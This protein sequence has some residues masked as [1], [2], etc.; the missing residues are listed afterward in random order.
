MAGI[1][2]GR[3][4]IAL[5]DELFGDGEAD[6]TTRTLS[7]RMEHQIDGNAIYVRRFGGTNLCYAPW[8]D[9][10]E[11]AA[12]TSYGWSIHFMTWHRAT[13]G[14]P[15]TTLEVYADV[16]LPGSATDGK[17]AARLDAFGF[18]DGDMGVIAS[19]GVVEFDE[20]DNSI[21][22]IAVDWSDAGISG[23][24]KILLVLWMKSATNETSG[25]SGTVLYEDPGLI[26]GSTN[27]E[28]EIDGTTY[29]KV[30]DGSGYG[31]VYDP[32][33]QRSDGAFM[34]APAFAPTSSV[35][36]DVYQMSVI[37]TKAIRVRDTID[38][39]RIGDLWTPKEPRE[40]QAQ[41][42]V[43]GQHTRSHGAN[44]DE[45]YL[46]PRALAFGPTGRAKPDATW[47]GNRYPRWMTVA[48]DTGGTLDMYGCQIDGTASRLE[49]SGWLH[50]AYLEPQTFRSLER[51]I[52]WLV[53]LTLT[54]KVEQLKPG[55]DWSG[56]TNYGSESVDLDRVPMY[57]LGYLSTTPFLQQYYGAWFGTSPSGAHTDQA[58]TYREG[59][60]YEEDLGIIVPF[61]VSVDVPADTVDRTKL[62]R[63]SLELSPIGA[64]D[65][66]ANDTD[67]S[68]T[69]SNILCT[70][71]AAN[72][73]EHPR[74]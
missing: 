52:R 56:V 68:P 24:S 3:N 42:P 26:K 57:S 67:F 51:Y 40:M 37:Y 60:L 18:V 11:P 1:Y 61:T 33:Y 7:A 22:T 66:T 10:S 36:V 58:M 63:A 70:L 4:F 27:V 43:L 21:H 73:E 74:F 54:L 53:D 64:S 69:L 55:A 41:D 71:I 23:S 34:T 16:D 28:S 13:P 19:S 62:I 5:D 14:K 47:T 2:D 65:V 49:C 15:S 32:I 9:A 25:K 20:A 8:E 35:S 29:L 30:T 44:L 48:G 6:A 46:E 17:M 12:R 31:D 39:T 45:V 38:T 72:V 50:L 59:Q